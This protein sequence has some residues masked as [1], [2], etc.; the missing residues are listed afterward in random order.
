[1]ETWIMDYSRGSN[2]EHVRYSNG[3]GLFEFRMVKQDGHHF[4]NRC[5]FLVHKYLI[6]IQLPDILSTIQVTVY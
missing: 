1:M 3:K 6:S 5:L 2:N 4:N